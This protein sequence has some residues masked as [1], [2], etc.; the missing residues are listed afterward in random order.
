MAWPCDGVAG[1]DVFDGGDD[2]VT[3]PDGGEDGRRDGR[4]DGWPQLLQL[5]QGP[6]HLLQLLL[7]STLRLLCQGCL[8]SWQTHVIQSLITSKPLMYGWVKMFFEM[9][10][11]VPLWT[12][13][14]DHFWRMRT[15]C[16]RQLGFWVM[17]CEVQ[18]SQ[19]HPPLCTSTS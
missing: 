14:A 11:V 12:Y 5:A 10:C 17:L 13:F 2:W 7:T 3:D 1:Q 8:L 6:V 15:G 19:T 4:A 18:L 9:F 16:C